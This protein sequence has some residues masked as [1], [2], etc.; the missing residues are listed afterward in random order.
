MM[1]HP[2]GI[3]IWELLEQE[4]AFATH[5]DVEEFRKLK[6][7]VE[8][9]GLSDVPFSLDQ[10]VLTAEEAMGIRIAFMA[11]AYIVLLSEHQWSET[12]RATMGSWLSMSVALVVAANGQKELLIESL[13]RPNVRSLLAQGT[14]S[15]L[16]LLLEQPTWLILG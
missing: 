1:T 6:P 16:H 15:V 10:A 5:P 8:A 4:P 2:S 3:K 13:L 9:L 7:L 11:H 12:L 14:L